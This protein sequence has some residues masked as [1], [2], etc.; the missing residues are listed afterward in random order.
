MFGDALIDCGSIILRWRPENV[1]F[2]VCGD[3][4]VKASEAERATP[5]LSIK[6]DMR[7]NQRF[8]NILLRVSKHIVVPSYRHKLV[9]Y[10]V[11]GHDVPSHTGLM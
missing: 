6:Q 10:M 8:K 4:I 9:L 7:L 1:H 11:T 3:Y 2:C 5:S